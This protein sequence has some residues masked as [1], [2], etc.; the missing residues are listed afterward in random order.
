MT[1]SRISS[2]AALLTL[3]VASP[4]TAQ[5][6]GTFTWQTQPYC[7]VLSITVIQHGG[8]YQLIGADNLC[9][10][11]TAPLTG[12]AVPT[13]SGVAFGMAIALP[14]GRTAHLSAGITLAGLSGTWNDADG[15][16]GPLSFATATGGSPRPAPAIA[17]AIG[18]SQL[19]PTVYGGSGVAPTLARSDHLHDDRYFTEAETTILLAGKA[20]VGEVVTTTES[21]RTVETATNSRSITTTVAGRLDIRMHVGIGSECS[22]T[23]GG[24][25]YFLTVDNVP[26]LSS[27]QP[28]SEATSRFEGTLTGVTAASV[29]AGTH[30]I[31]VGI[32]CPGASTASWTVLNL[33]APVVVTVLR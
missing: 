27:V 25:F 13:A 32:E 28:V 11:G 26:V 3:A 23:P 33:N 9:G 22:P 8:V 15:G 31:G 6:I 1:L 29:P 18:V 21:A 2:A 16:T 12:T 10:S 7:N 20:N 24:K 5:V 14:T 17:T 19:A 30:S 4:S